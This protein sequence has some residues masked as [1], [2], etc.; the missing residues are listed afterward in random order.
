MQSLWGL[1]GRRHAGDEPAPLPPKGLLSFRFNVSGRQSRSVQQLVLLF[2]SKLGCEPYRLR[3]QWC[4][5]LSSGLRLGF[6]GRVGLLLPSVAIAIL[7]A[8]AWY[9][10]ACPALGL[11]D[12]AA[13]GISTI[14]A[15]LACFLA[16]SEL[17]VGL[18]VAARRVPSTGLRLILRLVEIAVIGAPILAATMWL[19][20]NVNSGDDQRN[21]MILGGLIWAGAFLGTTI[22]FS[23]FAD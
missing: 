20:G 1:G 11:S 13:I 6:L 3:P 16:T 21:A 4:P 9:Y 22:A 8:R 2:L 19:V 23:E 18:A 12:P 15:F 5:M 17:I 7:A 10:Q 14:V